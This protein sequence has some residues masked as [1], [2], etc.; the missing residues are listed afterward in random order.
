MSYWILSLGISFTFILGTYLTLQYKKQPLSGEQPASTF[1]MI[2]I[3][4][5]S[6]LDGGFILLPMTEF[7]NYSKD[8]A[9]SFTTPL[10]IEL[11]LWG[12]TVWLLFY[13]STLYFLTL[14][15]KLK[16]FERKEVKILNSLVVLTTCAFTLSLLLNL[17]P[18]YIYHDNI[19]SFL[20]LVSFLLVVCIII[21]ALTMSTK[22]SFMTKLSKFSVYLFILLTFYLLTSFNFNDKSME[23]SLLHLNQYLFNAHQFILPFNEYHEFYLAWWL[24]WTIMLG[25]F[26]A[27]FVKHLKPIKLLLAMSVI[28][29]IPTFVW[30]SVLYHI[31][32]TEQTITITTALIMIFLAILFVVN[33]LDF[34]IANYA[35]TLKLGRAQLSNIGFILTNTVVL[36]CLT[37]L[38]KESLLFIEWTAFIVVLIFL[39]GL[40]LTTYQRIE[41]DYKK[42]LSFAEHRKINYKSILTL[43]K[44]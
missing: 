16:L 8:I 17:L 18:N 13:V 44:Q 9:F 40:M 30:F 36:V 21:F 26:V 22:V 1:T 42:I 5:T 34:M 19:L 14:E 7:P 37:Y 4:F 35:N 32:V 6:G 41:P 10:A 28:P 25:Q 38:F 24:T 20:P 31:H 43:F 11:G 27:K 33:S 29:M 15:P 3:L 12:L 2:A 39:Y 23:A